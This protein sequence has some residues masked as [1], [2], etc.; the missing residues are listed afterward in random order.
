MFFFNKK[1]DIQCF[2]FPTKASST[3]QA[4]YAIQCL[5]AIIQDDDEKL[6]MF[7]L[8]LDQIKVNNAS[9]FVTK[10]KPSTN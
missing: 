6:K 10:Q 9:F 3:K 5:N 2:I 4:K 8:I 1:S 7:A